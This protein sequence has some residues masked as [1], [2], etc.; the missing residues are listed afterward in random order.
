M[1]N[2]FKN[3]QGGYVKLFSFFNLREMEENRMEVKGIEGHRDRDRTRT[4]LS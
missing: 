1:G 2:N 3:S 4:Y